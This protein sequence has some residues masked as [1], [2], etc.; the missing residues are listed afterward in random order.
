MFGVR[1]E[2]G[3]A[4]FSGFDEDG[5]PLAQYDAHGEKPQVEPVELHHPFGFIARPRDPDLDDEGNP[6]EGKA[7]NL[8]FAT[9][10]DTLHAWLGYDP[11]FIPN[12]PQLKKGGSAQYCAAGSFRVFDGEDGTETLY[13]PVGDSA[14]VVTTG[15]DGSGKPYIGIQHSSGLA[16]TLLEHSVTIKNEAGDAYI[17]VN[18]SGITLNGNTKLNGAVIAG[19][20]TAAVPMVKSPALIALL[21]ALAAMIDGKTGAPSTAVAAVAAAAAGLPTVALSS[22]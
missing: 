1:T 14:H 11:R 12:I 22:T 4:T 13:V 8:F 5:F 9:E 21:N 17:E 6:K 7:C 10:G 3:I 18:S 16:I 2:I 15:I 19:T 20:V